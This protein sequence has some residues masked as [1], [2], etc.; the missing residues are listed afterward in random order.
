MPD[1]SAAMLAACGGLRI[2]LTSG[3]ARNANFLAHDSKTSSWL[4]RKRFAMKRDDW[5]FWISLVW[6]VS[7]CGAAAWALASPW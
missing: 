1:R 6:F 2:E 5:L 7:L 4:G 3:V